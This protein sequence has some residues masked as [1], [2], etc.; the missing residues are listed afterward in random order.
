MRF[1]VIPFYIAEGE[2]FMKKSIRVLLGFALVLA[3]V[4]V[5]T[6]GYFSLLK[7]KSNEPL[8]V[9]SGGV[10]FDSGNYVA[11]VNGVSVIADDTGVRIFNEKDK[12][13]KVIFDR[14]AMSPMFDGETA[15]FMESVIADGN[16]TLYKGDEIVSE[17]DYGAWYNRKIYSYDIESGKTEE[18][19]TCNYEYAEIVA[20][21]GG[22]IYYTDCND[23]EIGNLD[24]HRSALCLYKYNIENQKRTKLLDA[25]AWYE[26]VD[27][28]VFY[29]TVK[30]NKGMAYN[31]LFCFDLKTE[32]SKLVTDE[33]ALFI[34]AENG[35]I[36]Y[37]AR[38]YLYNEEGFVDANDYALKKTDLVANK[39][40]TISE[41]DFYDVGE[42]EL[43]ADCVGDD[44]YFNYASTAEVYK[45]E[46]YSYNLKT[47]EL[48]KL[49]KS[50]IA[51]NGWIYRFGNQSVIEFNRDL[52]DSDSVTELYR[53]DGLGKYTKIYESSDLYDFKLTEN[54][55][56][57]TKPLSDGD[58]GPEIEFIPLEIK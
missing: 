37:L 49:G 28:R 8:S 16:V 33:K 24:L 55:L 39:T 42:Y 26:T 7:D 9:E 2:I 23:D 6:T 19:V 12:T 27:D 36:Y 34:K 17:D 40:A 22:D 47:N 15:F 5:G 46:N 48:T 50:D 57:K 52:N 31:D 14:P 45:F 11:S 18:L 30:F 51:F 21:N 43:W 56:Y 38:T 32:T 29:Q 53:I 54:G 25:F 10:I 1:I 44:I 35:V 41:L 3:L 58:S 20:I 4:A 13:Q